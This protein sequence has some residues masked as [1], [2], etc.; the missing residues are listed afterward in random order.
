MAHLFTATRTG[1]SAGLEVRGGVV[2]L[3][4]SGRSRRE[5]RV[6]ADPGLGSRPV[7][8]GVVRRGDVVSLTPGEP[9]DAVVVRVRTE[10]AY[11]RGCPGRLRLGGGWTLLTE[12]LT[13]WGGAGRLGVMPDALL[14]VRGD[15][16]GVV[17]VTFSGGRSKGGGVRWLAALRRGCDWPSVVLLDCHP[18]ARPDLRPGG[19]L[20]EG[21]AARVL[22]MVRALGVSPEAL[23]DAE[24]AL[25]PAPVERF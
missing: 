12:G 13:A 10:E 21:E 19:I 14:A 3:G 17:Q 20:L 7:V 22:G 11:T 6:A 15:A 18:D 25:G 4:E 16:E 23:E 5:V 9:G 8:A 1:L 24:R 2:V